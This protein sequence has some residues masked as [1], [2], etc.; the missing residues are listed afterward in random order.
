MATGRRRSDGGPWFVMPG[1]D[2]RRHPVFLRRSRRRGFTILEVL[3]ALVLLLT[4]A[5]LSIVSFMSMR[6]SRDLE[7]SPGMVEGIVR[8]ARAEACNLGR[9][10]RLTVQSDT[11]GLQVL[12]EP[13]PLTEPNVFVPY[14]ASSWAQHLT[15]G[16]ATVVRCEIVDPNIPPPDES[17][18]N[19]GD[20]PAVTAGI[21][22]APDGSC[23]SAQIE[24]NSQDVADDRRAIVYIDGLS[25]LITHDII[26]ASDSEGGSSPP[27]SSGSS[28]G[29]ASHG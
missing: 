8:L 27:S 22:F 6:G 2:W 24:L 23:D 16:T 4:L 3:L 10:I 25:G 14:T 19:A 5:G 12:W 17:D 18:P 7:E 15:F 28:T 9:R 11:G 13:N 29:G 1:P 26:S 21:T 20:N